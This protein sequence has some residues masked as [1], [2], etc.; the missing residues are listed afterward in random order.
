MEA[1]Q[2]FGRKFFH[3]V[4]HESVERYAVFILNIDNNE[5]TVVNFTLH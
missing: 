1:I 4:L 3:L 5:I 2:Q